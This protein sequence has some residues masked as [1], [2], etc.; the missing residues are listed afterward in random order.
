MG[1]KRKTVQEYVLEN[2][3]FEILETSETDIICKYC[4]VV[5]SL[6]KSHLS[7]RIA[8]HIHSVRHQRLKKTWVDGMGIAGYLAQTAAAMMPAATD[9]GKDVPDMAEHCCVSIKE[10][11][12]NS[13]PEAEVPEELISPDLTVS[14]EEPPREQNRLRIPEADTAVKNSPGAE[15]PAAIKPKTHR[16]ERNAGDSQGEIVSCLRRIIAIG[17]QHI[18]IQRELLKLKRA[19]YANT[20]LIKDTGP[21][22]S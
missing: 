1:R 13:G 21:P 3:D 19:K 15:S 17:E 22:S 4:H 7:T 18:Q 9:L 11:I 2:Q 16:P 6:D 8:E 14:E 5:L 10:E 20:A 12:C